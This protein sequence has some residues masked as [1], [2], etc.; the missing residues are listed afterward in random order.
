[1]PIH[2][3]DLAKEH[4]YSSRFKDIYLNIVRN[5]LPSYVLA[6]RVKTGTLNYVVINDLLFCINIQE[7]LA[8]ITS[9]I[10]LVIPEK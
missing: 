8:T 6:Q 2:A 5:Q 4:E 10:L 9:G 3:V 7:M 1:M